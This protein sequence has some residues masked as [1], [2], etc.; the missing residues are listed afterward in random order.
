MMSYTCGIQKTETKTHQKTPSSEIQRTDGW[1]SEV[2]WGQGN[3]EGAQKIQSS[4]IK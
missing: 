2:G 1:L 4:I 3:N